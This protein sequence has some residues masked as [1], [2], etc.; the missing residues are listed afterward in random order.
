MQNT[1]LYLIRHSIKYD[2]KD[3]VENYNTSDN[4]Q[5]KNEKLVLSVEGEKRAEILSNEKE[6]Q[7]IDIVYA[8]VLVRTLETAKYL[9]EKQNLK[10]NLDN[11][12]DERRR[13]R[14]NDDI[15]PDWFTKQF[16]DE[17]FKTVGGESQKDVRKRMDEV[18]S[19]IIKNNKGKRIAIFSHGLAITFL[20]LKWC[21]LD[22][23]FLDRKLVFSFKGKEVFNNRINSPDVFK[24]VF[25]E[26]NNVLSIENI[27]FSDLDYEDFVNY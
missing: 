22:N 27:G 6:L 11:R 19:E 9:L 1:T 14:P 25:D 13:G 16:L 12:L 24:L 23:I 18:I 3:I 2:I 15:Y 5:I 7:N 17:N 10:I 4:E 20:L 26:E 8:S 21:H